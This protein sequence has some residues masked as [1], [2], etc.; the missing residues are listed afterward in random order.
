[1]AKRGRPR[2]NPI[3]L[4]ETIQTKI[5]EIVKE[6]MNKEFNEYHQVVEDFKKEIHEQKEWD[7][8]ENMM[9][10]GK[11]IDYFDPT[12]SYQLTG[13]KPITKTKSLDFNPN[14]FTVSR[15]TKI[16]T[17]HYTQFHAGTKAYRDFWHEEYVRCRNGYTVNGYTITGDHYFFLNYYQLLLT[18][19]SE[20]AAGGRS[21][22][23]P[24][25]LVAQ[26]E[27]LHYLELCKRLRKNAALMKARGLILAP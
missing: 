3:V 26:Y 20:K 14:W 16:A 2:K 21:I 27:Y 5:Q 23:F 12:L 24:N 15:D 17:G 22:G 9:M 25:F 10:D 8:D 11:I 1:M 13:Y 7:V 4:P 6:E 18:Q 19:S